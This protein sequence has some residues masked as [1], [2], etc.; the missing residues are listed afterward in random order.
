MIGWARRNR[1]P[2]IRQLS[3]T[4]FQ[5]LFPVAFR[6]FA[7][8]MGYPDSYIEP[9]IRLATSQLAYPSLLAFGAFDGRGRLVGF[10][11]GYRAQPGQWWAD[12]VARALELPASDRSRD[13][14]ADAFELCEIHVSPHAQ[15]H[16]LGRALLRAITGSQP[17]RVIILSTP[18]GLTKA[19]RLYAAEGYR[20]VASSFHFR[21]DPRPFEILAKAVRDD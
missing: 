11:Y 2:E 5:R 9:R 20:S 3:I 1:G 16:G 18:S 8:A 10:A 19:A 21:G 7:E 14:L 13:W 12:E 4:E 6:I 15:G 17:A